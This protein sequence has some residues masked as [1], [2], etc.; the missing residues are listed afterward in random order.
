MK[1]PRYRWILWAATL[2]AAV[3]FVS[4]MGFLSRGHGAT[5]PKG[6][7]L[8]DTLMSHIRNDYLEERDPVQTAEGTFRGMVNSLDPLS[9][10]LPKDLASRY[11]AQ[12]AKATETGM[13]LLKHDGAFPQVVALADKS[14]AATAGVEMGDLLSA[15]DG[16]GTLNMSLAEVKLLLWGTDEKPVAIRV[17]R[18][19]DTHNL[20]VPRAVLFPAAYTFVRAAG[21]SQPA[22]LIVHRFDD[23]L[24]E[25]VRKEIG[26]ALK[27]RKAPL[28]LDLRG[29][30]D[31][32][33]DEAGRLA[34][35]F[36]QA[37]DAGRFE[38]RDGSREPFSCPAVAD[39][40][41]VPVVV[42]VDAGTA[43]PAELAAGLLQEIGKTKIV[44]Y[45]TTGLV[46]RTT[47]FPLKD[48]SAVL[49]TSAV[50]VLPSGRKLWDEGLA[51]DASIPVDKLNDKTYLERTLP[52]LPKL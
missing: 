24:V 13:V 35:L 1:V 11:K 8:L 51:P 5:P 19:N 12:T 50:F 9:A 22:R 27:G 21:P 4:E 45:K 46:G 10:Y 31:G 52:L 34:N 25:A 2:A 3:F 44:G 16:R 14:P 33:P 49:L 26:P 41:S 40:A 20:N 38:G 17:L 30:Q 48:D 28:V 18:G 6:F 7:E 29:C 42:W 23:S 37:A 43:G 32:A 47:L 36:I 39:L 15:V